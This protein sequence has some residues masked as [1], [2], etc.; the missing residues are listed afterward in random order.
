MTGLVC[1]EP[2]CKWTEGFIC[3]EH[4]LDLVPPDRKRSEPQGEDPVTADP[5]DQGPA[6]EA[7]GASPPDD[8]WHCHAPVPDPAAKLCVQCAEPLIR[9]PLIIKFTGGHVAVAAE[10]QTLLGR[11]AG[12]SPHAQLFAAYDNVSR[13]HATIGM[14][15][16]GA[17]IRDEQSTNGTFVNGVLIAERERH[18][19]ADGDQIRLGAKAEGSVTLRPPS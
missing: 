1:P 14:D 4:S 19:L 9:L 5:G 15:R 6:A 13:L 2:A 3:P 16:G 18:P 12:E 17:W 8:C 11:S 10:E 7:W